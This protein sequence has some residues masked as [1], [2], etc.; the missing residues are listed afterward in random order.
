[1]FCSTPRDGAAFCSIVGMV[2]VL[3]SN[4]DGMFRPTLKR[5]VL[6]FAVSWGWGL[7]LGPHLSMHAVIQSEAKNLECIHVSAALCLRDF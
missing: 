3:P 1:M 4:G 5:T 2:G 7:V 6:R